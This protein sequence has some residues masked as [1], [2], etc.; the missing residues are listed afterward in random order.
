MNH[1]CCAEKHGQQNNF[2]PTHQ[3]WSSLRDALQRMREA[4]FECSRRAQT[5]DGNRLFLERN[6]TRTEKQWQRQHKADQHHIT[7]MPGP[8][9]D[10]EFSTVDFAEKI[11]KKPEWTSPSAHK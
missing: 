2:L 6:S 10:L 8:R 3:P 7:Q 11:L 5:T 1:H 9:R 4:G